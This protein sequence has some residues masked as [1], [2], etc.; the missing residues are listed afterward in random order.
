MV[1]LD[2]IV[3]GTFHSGDGLA[4][5]NGV[6]QGYVSEARRLG[7]RLLN[8]VTVAG[9]TVEDGTVSGV[10]T[11]RGKVAA[12]VVVD[13]AGPWAAEIGRMAG[14]EIP[15]KPIR[16][17][18][19]V[20]TPI[21]DLPSDFPFVIDFAR[22]LY[23]HR[24]G[25]AILTGMS[26]A[27][28]VPGFDESVDEAWEAVHIEA[29][30]R[31]LPVLEQV[32]IASRWAGLYEV[33]PDAHPILGPIPGVKGL[34]CIGGFSGHGFQHGPVCGMLLAEEIL[35]GGAHTLAIGALSMERFADGRRNPEYNVV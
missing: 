30:V 28:E 4:D 3:A 12:P 32:G 9:V 8:D 16:R 13:A 34:Y 23:F 20:T 18:I 26:N 11:D 25:P 29:A 6:V 14:V 10:V 35:D 31:R 1:N 2:G 24:E 19:A 7:A 33:T 27:D 5:P 21:P 15:I 17:Q 22:S